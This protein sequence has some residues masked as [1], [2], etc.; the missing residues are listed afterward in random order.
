MWELPIW[1]A[2]RCHWQ[3]EHCGVTAIAGDHHVMQPIVSPWSVSQRREVELLQVPSWEVQFRSQICN[4]HPL[5]FSLSCGPVQLIERPGSMYE[6][7]GRQVRD[8]QWGQPQ[9][10]GDDLQLRVHKH[11]VFELWICSVH[12]SD[13]SICH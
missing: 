3:V 4:G 11:L 12:G 1:Y 6:V 13:W 9:A 7:P 5:L 8:V 2:S 10:Q